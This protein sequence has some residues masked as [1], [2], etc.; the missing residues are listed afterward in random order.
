LIFT[1]AAREFGS[2]MFRDQRV[3]LQQFF[4]QYHTTGSVL[5][6]SRALARALC[7]F[8]DAQSAGQA[9][10]NGAA[11]TET[12]PTTAH[13]MAPNSAAPREI[14]EVGPGTGAVTAQLVRKL[15]PGD[16][17]TLVEL[18]D[19]FVRH[20]QRR[21]DT[22]PAFKA[23]ADRTQILHCR[24]EDLP[25]EKHY[26]VVISGLPLNNFAVDEV[27]HILEVF[28]RLLGSG[29]TLSFFEYIAI[30]RVK[31]LISGAQGRT[32][33]RGISQVLSRTLDGREIKC[34]W[35]WPNVPPA[36]VHHV[37]F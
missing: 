22:E 25:P 35:V 6:S 17:L 32:R 20:L 11:Q 24:L 19:G 3:F 28:Q 1:K 2:E 23:V 31:S 10:T 26:R 30:R 5:P 21:F 34:D 13:T 16:Q 27:A 12:V 9:L 4:Q 37:R 33:L 14:L 36:W 8:V 15:Q 7:R 18:N 29:G